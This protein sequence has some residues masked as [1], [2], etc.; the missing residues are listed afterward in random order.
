M[1]V[2]F[3][4]DLKHCRACRF[5]LTARPSHRRRFRTIKYCSSERV[6][7]TVSLRRSHTCVNNIPCSIGEYLVYDTLLTACGCTSVT[8]ELKASNPLSVGVD[9]LPFQEVSTPRPLF[10]PKGSTYWRTLISFGQ[11][12]SAPREL[13]CGTHWAALEN[14]I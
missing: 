4:R 1:S 9:F 10:G 13:G 14:C 3:R 2:R 6:A 5:M 7:T 11:G 12:S 8:N